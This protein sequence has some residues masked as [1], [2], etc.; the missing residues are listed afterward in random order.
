MDHFVQQT[1]LLSKKKICL[2][3]PSTFLQAD[4]ESSLLCLRNRVTAMKMICKA[5]MGEQG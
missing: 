3:C 1:Y 2:K 4:S 5:S